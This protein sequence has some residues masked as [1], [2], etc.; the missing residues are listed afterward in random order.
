MESAREALLRIPGCRTSARGYLARAGARA[1][2]VGRLRAAPLRWRRQRPPTPALALRLSAPRGPGSPPPGPPRPP[3]RDTTSPAGRV[4]VAPLP[5]RWASAARERVPTHLPGTLSGRPGPHEAER[6]SDDSEGR[7]LAGPTGDSEWPPAPPT[8][9][10]DRFD[11]GPQPGRRTSPGCA[12]RAA[13]RMSPARRCPRPSA[14]RVHVDAA[15]P[16]VGPPG[17]PPGGFVSGHP[18]RPPQSPPAPWGLQSVGADGC[19]GARAP[20]A[21]GALPGSVRRTGR[22]GSGVPS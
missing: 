19:G 1:G 7:R 3:L 8:V 2:P 14:C 5:G 22:R 13:R 12:C 15:Q 17:L 10:H 6:S 11:D 20:I 4:V 21:T 16:S 9:L 18:G